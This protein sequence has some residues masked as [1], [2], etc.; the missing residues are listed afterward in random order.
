M[1]TGTVWAMVLAL[2]LMLAVVACSDRQA[3]EEEGAVERM[4][5][6]AAKEMGDRV[7]SPLDKAK[8]LKSLGDQRMEEMDSALHS[9]AEK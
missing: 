7:R 3:P 6:K 9:Q 8:E 2:F 4:T 5:T 1:K